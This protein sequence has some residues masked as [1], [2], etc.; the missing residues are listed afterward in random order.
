M[1]CNLDSQRLRIRLRPGSPRACRPQSSG[2][3]WQARP[4]GG[5]AGLPAEHPSFGGVTELL[6]ADDLGRERHRSG[7]WVQPRDVV[8]H[9]HRLDGRGIWRDR[10]ALEPGPGW[11]N[12]LPRIIGLGNSLALVRWGNLSV[13]EVLAYEMGLMNQLVRLLG[14]SL[15]GDRLPRFI[16]EHVRNDAL[17]TEP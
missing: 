14:P 10:G 7:R 9:L 11:V 2:A 13:S 8:R 3:R 6:E 12:T 16:H 5:D 17:R 15:Q 1:S 4:D